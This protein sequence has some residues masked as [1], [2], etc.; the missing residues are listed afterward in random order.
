MPLRC[1]QQTRSVLQFNDNQM[2]PINDDA[3]HKLRPLINIVKVTLH[4]FVR[5]GSELALDEVSVV[6]H[7][8]YGCAG[9]H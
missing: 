3:F 2:M 8:S 7:S 4:A 6:S 1:F 9:A 5:V